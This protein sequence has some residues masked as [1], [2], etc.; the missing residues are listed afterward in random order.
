[1]SSSQRRLDKVE[2][3]LAPQQVVL[4]WMQ[5]AHQ[6][7][8]MYEYVR[9]LKGG[10]ESAFPLYLLPDQVERAMKNQMKGRPRQEIV[11]AMRSAVRDTLF[12]FHL[13]QQVNHKLMEKQEAFLFRLRWLRAEL[14]RLRYQKMACQASPSGIRTRVPRRQDLTR[15]QEEVERFLEELH[16]LRLAVLAISKRYFGK[17]DLLFPAL[18][19]SLNYVLKAMEVLAEMFN[20]DLAPAKRARVDVVAMGVRAGIVGGVQMEFL[21]DMARAEALDAMGDNRAAVAIIER[22]I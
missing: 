19:E 12:L 7:P 21:V 1:M 9:S 6:F 10:P 22:H 14:G 11:R 16:C 17:H 8:S 15:W 20:E 2:A 5:Q 18:T 13:H 4:L 3:T